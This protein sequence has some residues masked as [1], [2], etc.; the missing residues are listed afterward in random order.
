MIVPLSW[1]F[2]IMIKK[3]RQ[4]GSLLNLQKSLAKADSS[5]FRALNSIRAILSNLSLWILRSIMADCPV[6]SFPSAL[7]GTTFICSLLK[8]YFSSVGVSTE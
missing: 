7:Y 8:T 6:F 4:V 5:G 1:L 2:T 3:V